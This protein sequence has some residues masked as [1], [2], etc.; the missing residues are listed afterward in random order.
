MHK[1]MYW[2]WLSWCTKPG[3]PYYK[4]CT[5]TNCGQA[6]TDMLSCNTVEPFLVQNITVDENTENT[7]TVVM[8][9]VLTNDPVNVI[10]FT[11]RVAPKSDPRVARFYFTDYTSNLVYYQTD[12]LNNTSPSRMLYDANL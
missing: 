6:V 10:I 9:T 12:L 1:Q 2:P 7:P 5:D 4:S 3:S 11:N 8:Y